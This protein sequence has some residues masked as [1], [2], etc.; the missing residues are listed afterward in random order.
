M[1]EGGAPTPPRSVRCRAPDVRLPGYLP[2]LGHGLVTTVELTVVTPSSARAAGRRGGDPA[3]LPRTAAARVGRPTSRYS[4]TCRCWPCSSCSSS[5]CRRSAITFPLFTAAVVIARVPGRVLR[6]GDPGRHQHG[7]GGPGRGG[8][9]DRA[10]L[11]PV[12]AARDPAAGAARGDPADRQHL[13]RA[14]DEHLAGRR[15][16]RGRADPGG[17]Q[18]EPGRGPADPVFTGAGLAYMLL[19][20]ASVVTGRLERRLAIVR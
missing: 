10:D 20:A 3:D 4:R 8:Q 9:G 14:A 13:H 16:R 18:R 1:V 2:E 7:R 6:G 12:P 5:P 15:R 19:A 11:R 17:Q